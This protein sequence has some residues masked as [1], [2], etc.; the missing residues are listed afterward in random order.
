MNSQRGIPK[1]RRWLYICLLLTMVA[2]YPFWILLFKWVA[3][4]RMP[5][6]LVYSYRERHARVPFESETWK[7]FPRSS[8][9]WPRTDLRPIRLR[10]IDDLVAK[11]DFKGKTREE[12]E[13]LLG[14]KTKTEYFAEW[15]L[16]YY[17][18]P[19]R[20]GN[21]IGD[22]EW[23]VFRFHTNGSVQDCQVVHD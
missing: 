18:G 9:E 19:G 3:D 5:G 8:N 4:P 17:L 12:V 15:D 6:G 20:Y 1:Y 13:S 23:L 11:H 22:S 7:K 14:S 2:A 21:A 10:M 16:V